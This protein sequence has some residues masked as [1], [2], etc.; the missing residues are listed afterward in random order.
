MKEWEMNAALEA[1]LSGQGE[2]PAFL[3]A[4]PADAHERF[5]LRAAKRLVR[6]Y[7]LHRAHECGHADLM[8]ALRN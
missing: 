8:L 4:A 3:D 2:R 7:E 1:Y 6:S 5:L